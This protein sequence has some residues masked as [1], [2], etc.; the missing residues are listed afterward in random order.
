MYVPHAD[1]SRFLP[2]TRPF[3]YAAAVQP[4]HF[5]EATRKYSSRIVLLGRCVEDNDVV[6][7]FGLVE[8][9]ADVA[10]GHRPP[11]SPRAPRPCTNIVPSET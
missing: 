8:R 2:K 10:T 11:A 3:Y 5:P 9:H 6:R 1:L 4:E 7:E